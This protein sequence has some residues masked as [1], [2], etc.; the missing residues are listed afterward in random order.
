[1]RNLIFANITRLKKSKLFWTGVILSALYTVFLLIMNYLEM[2]G[3]AE[4]TEVSLNWFF[5]SAISVSTI[6]CPIYSGFFVGTEY[7]DGTIRNKLIAGHER[8]NIYLANGLTIF[9]VEI[10]LFL[11]SAAIIIILG[12]PMFGLTIEYPLRFI[13]YLLAGM[14]ML[15]EFASL[16]TMVSTIIS[17]KTSSVSA[18][19]IIYAVLYIITNYLRIAVFSYYGAEVVSSGIYNEVTKFIFEF[20]YDFLP[21]GQSLQISSGFILHPY[22]FFFYSILNIMLTTVGAVKIYAQNCLQAPAE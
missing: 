19:L 5:F 2:T 15:A 13:L 12:I 8:S 4:I 3:S 18:C 10:L 11:V 20:L 9:N 21:T 17:N 14:F 7:N 6:F 22:S 1:M 16:F